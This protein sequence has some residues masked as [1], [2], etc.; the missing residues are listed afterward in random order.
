M[1]QAVRNDLEAD[2]CSGLD[3]LERSRLTVTLQ[4]ISN[5]PSRPSLSYHHHQS[6]FARY[7]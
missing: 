1:A 3:S 4:T 6:G 5:K 7:V 2:G